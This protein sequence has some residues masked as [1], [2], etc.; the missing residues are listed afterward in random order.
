MCDRVDAITSIEATEIEADGRP[1]DYTNVA[2]GQLPL[3]QAAGSSCHDAPKINR[4][5]R[6][7]V[8]DHH[9]HQ[10][11]TNATVGSAEDCK[12]LCAQQLSVCHGVTFFT[13]GSFQGANCFLVTE[14]F[15]TGPWVPGTTQCRRADAQLRPQVLRDTLGEYLCRSCFPEADRNGS[16]ML[17]EQWNGCCSSGQCDFQPTEAPTLFPTRGPTAGPSARPSRTPTTHPTA[18]PTTSDP[19]DAPTASAPPT[20]SPTTQFPTSHPSTVPS[21]PAPTDAPLSASPTAT[22]A[23]TTVPT[24]AP[25][26]GPTLSPTIP[27]GVLAEPMFDG[28]GHLRVQGTC[29][30]AVAV[31]Y[32]NC[33]TESGVVCDHNSPATRM[34]ESGD[35][36]EPGDADESG[37][38]GEANT[39]FECESCG[40]AACGEP[41]GYLDCVTTIQAEF[42]MQTA[43]ER[44]GAPVVSRLIAIDDCACRHCGRVRGEPRLAT[45]APTVS[46]TAWSAP[47]VTP[48]DA[49]STSTPTLGPTVSPSRGPSHVPT[50]SPTTVCDT[51][52]DPLGAESCQLISDRCCGADTA[53]AA[54]RNALCE[55]TCCMTQCVNEPSTDPTAQP[56]Y[57]GDTPAPTQFPSLAPTTTPPLYYVFCDDIATSVGCTADELAES[58]RGTRLPGCDDAC[59]TPCANPN[60]CQNGGACVISINA[61][62]DLEANETG[63]TSYECDCPAGYSG[64]DCEIDPCEAV[65]D[66]CLNGGV[67]DVVLGAPVCN[68]SWTPGGLNTGTHCERSPCEPNPCQHNGTCSLDAGGSPVCDCAFPFA[69]PWCNATFSLE[70]YSV[71]QPYFDAHAPWDGKAVSRSKVIR[72]LPALGVADCKHQCA[73]E[74]RCMGLTYFS[75]PAWFTN[76]SDSADDPRPHF[77]IANGD[78][79]QEYERGDCSLFSQPLSS[80]S[81]VQITEVCVGVEPAVHLN[82]GVGPERLTDGLYQPW[83]A[84]TEDF[85][86]H[87]VYQACPEVDEVVVPFVAPSRVHAVRV[88]RRCDDSETPTSLLQVS[89]GAPVPSG[90]PVGSGVPADNATLTWTPCGT[91]STLAELRC[92]AGADPA[93]QFWERQ[94]NGDMMSATMIRI[95]RVAG[96]DGRC[97]PERSSARIARS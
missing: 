5:A 85:L 20:M 51:L 94:C 24:L 7:D 59:D 2:I 17:Q 48:S 41:A 16:Q 83:T 57:T 88:W 96:G 63:Q 89:Y 44:C 56:S 42:V 38:S 91:P 9:T 18:T 73:T 13:E 4:V 8:T 78:Q 54:V 22:L 55:A 79:D 53:A 35:S 43:G 70:H 67:C 74:P 11:G 81:W 50:W 66:F 87:H 84:E 82:V 68:C 45:R 90:A 3:G 65:P 86:G 21:R 34:S 95:S 15:S 52:S 75:T 27:A 47:T 40:L 37:D 58:N 93:G 33:S 32:G 23:P 69:G 92:D 77:D 49:P 19:T 29:F 61:T 25:S 1:L 10:M 71:D 72:R 28:C 31:A 36:S 64:G 46:P 12:H 39:P 6:L 26:A 97:F 30:A 60:P 80:D 14:P 62:L 76:N